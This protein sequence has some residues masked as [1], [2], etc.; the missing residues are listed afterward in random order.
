LHFAEIP[1]KVEKITKIYK[2]LEKQ[3][4][5]E[6][7]DNNLIKFKNFCGYLEDKLIIQ[8][9]LA[10]HLNLLEN[11]KPKVNYKELYNKTFQKFLEKIL[12][13]LSKENIIYTLSLTEIPVKENSLNESKIFKLL[14]LMKLKGELINS[15]HL[16]LSNSHRKLYKYQIYKNLNDVNYVDSNILIDILQNSDKLYEFKDGIIEYDDKNYSPTKILQYESEETFDTLENRFI[17][18]FLKEIELILKDLKEFLFLNELKEIKNEIEYALQS[19][20]FSEVKDMNYFPSNSQVLMK[21]SGYREI[22]KI[23][24]LLHT[25]FV[26]EFFRNL[27]LAYS[28]K[29]MATLWEYYVLIEILKILKCK[30]G[31][32]QIEINFEEK[33]KNNTIYEKA[34]FRF[35]NG[36]ILFYQKTLKSYSSLEFRPDFYIEY[37]NKKFIFDA[38]FRIFEDNKKDILQNMH[39]YRDGL[40]VNYAIAI[41]L[42]NKKDNESS[43]NFWFKNKNN[44]KDLFL[45]NLFFNE[46]N[47]EGV[48]YTNLK[49]A[50]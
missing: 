21:K 26:P 31:N 20:I 38:K 19:H 37:N 13:E 23:Y 7:I 36:L 25:S 16:I 15:L 44:K 24:R 48:G 17:K 28:L 3:G 1:L 34:K 30:F 39:Y 32:Y 45:N 47:L 2:Y 22:F 14:L 50:I 5:I 6:I 46:E 18:F 27:D 35:E 12:R 29:D 10:K 49:F 11:E 40:N 33:I 42:E 9:K 41:C 43:G 4:Q 8:R